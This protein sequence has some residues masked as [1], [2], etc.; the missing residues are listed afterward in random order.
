VGEGRHRGVIGGAWRVAHQDR[1][2]HSR[3]P[4]QPR[5]KFRRQPDALFTTQRS[6][7][8]N[9]AALFRSGFCGK[10]RA[11]TAALRLVLSQFTG[12]V[13]GTAA[14]AFGA[15]AAK[16]LCPLDGILGNSSLRLKR[17]Q[18]ALGAVEPLRLES[19]YCSLH[20]HWLVS[21]VWK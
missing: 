15:A 10:C 5:H 13:Q 7:L 17:A 21:S 6:A 2:R 18:D 8:A 3:S 19:R 20:G 11:Q 14:A 12:R 4:S 16:R 1:D 9:I